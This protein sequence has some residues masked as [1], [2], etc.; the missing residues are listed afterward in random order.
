MDDSIFNKLITIIQDIKPYNPND[1]IFDCSDCASV[2][3]VV[4]YNGMRTYFYTFL[5]F[6]NEPSYK[7][8]LASAMY[9]FC[10]HN[11]LQRA[12]ERFEIENAG[13]ALNRK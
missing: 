9:D 12:K 6:G 13:P 2:D 11:S 5:L 8:K 1:P 3:L 10:E 7:E 4:Y